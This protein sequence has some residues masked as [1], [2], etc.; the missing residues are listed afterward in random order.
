MQ[1]VNQQL[2]ALVT[3]T[4]KTNKVSCDHNYLL[5]ATNVFQSMTQEER[6]QMDPSSLPGL[7][8][9]SLEFKELKTAD[10]T[11]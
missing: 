3:E 11:G 6:K 10:L 1:N 9:W 7:K 4:G 5:H 2:K 8:R